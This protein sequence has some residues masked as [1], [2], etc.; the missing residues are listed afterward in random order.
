MSKKQ[1]E[2]K[3]KT[4]AQ[5]DGKTLDDVGKGL[6]TLRL[7]TP[8]CPSN[9]YVQATL[10]VGSVNFRTVDFGGAYFHLVQLCATCAV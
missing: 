4:L 10:G 2:E 7:C 3:M 5:R 1:I 8:L 9:A 6:S